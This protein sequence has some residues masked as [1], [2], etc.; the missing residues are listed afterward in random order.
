MNKFLT[1]IEFDNLL[2]NGYVNGFIYKYYSLVKR[3]YNMSFSIKRLKYEA[4]N[5]N[6]FDFVNEFLNC[7]YE[8][9]E[10]RYTARRAISVMKVFIKE[11]GNNMYNEKTVDK[12]V[13]RIEK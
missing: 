11:I 13:K 7:K 1:E 2:D 4:L 9:H 3:L 5:D 10:L 8:A 12:I 6:D